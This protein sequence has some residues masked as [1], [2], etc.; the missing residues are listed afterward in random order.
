MWLDITKP[1]DFLSSLSTNPKWRFIT[2]ILVVSTVWTIA[3]VDMMRRVVFLFIALT[4]SGIF[5]RGEGA[6]AS[7]VNV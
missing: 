6:I 4:A 3:S 5:D 7:K 2:A 1:T